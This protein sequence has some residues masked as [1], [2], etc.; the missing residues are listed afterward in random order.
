MNWDPELSITALRFTNVVGEGE[1]GTFARADDPAYRRD[2]LWTWVDARDG[3]QAIALAVQQAS[4]GLELYNIGA[5]ESGSAIP[6]AE[7]AATYFPDAEVRHPLAEF[8]PL[9]SIEKAR[10]RL[11]YQPAHAWRDGYRP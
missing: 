7:L 2:L 1:Y 8:E 4:P 5:A 6:S 10:S 9:I 3:A 11:G